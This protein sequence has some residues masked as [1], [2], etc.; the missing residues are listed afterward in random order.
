M[1]VLY[2]FYRFGIFFTIL[3]SYRSD[4][5]ELIW[6][7]VGIYV[8][9]LLLWSIEISF[10]GVWSN[11]MFVEPSTYFI[12]FLFLTTSSTN[13]DG[14]TSL[15]FHLLCFSKYL[16]G[17]LASFISYFSHFIS[18]W[19]EALGSAL[20]LALPAVANLLSEIR[21]MFYLILS[22]C[23]FSIESIE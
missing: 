10:G 5:R 21:E 13:T 6:F 7:I 9:A 8:D 11:R 3:V 14:L 1:F 20:A 22:L 19:I 2:A 18:Y 17:L 23:D 4:F 16:S 12:F 15:G